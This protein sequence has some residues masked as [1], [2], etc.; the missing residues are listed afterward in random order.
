[1]QPTCCVC[2]CECVCVCV[3]LSVRV[4]VCACVRRVCACVTERG[5]C[6]MGRMERKGGMHVRLHYSHSKVSTKHRVQKF[7]R[8]T[9]KAQVDTWRGL[10]RETVCVS[11][12][13]ARS[14]R[15]WRPT[16]LGGRPRQQ[17][18]FATGPCSSTVCAPLTLIM[19]SAA[20]TSTCSYS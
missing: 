8:Q 15:A 4:C 13:V 6:E 12:T 18:D 20:I 3:C 5:G 10:L 17:Q 19:Q 9:L 2:V 1:M 7:L 16:A 14:C 11:A